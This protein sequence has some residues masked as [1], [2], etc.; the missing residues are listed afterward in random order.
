MTATQLKNVIKNLKYIPVV[1]G[2]ITI[3]EA[4]ADVLEH[5]S[6]IKEWHASFPTP[7]LDDFEEAITVLLKLDTEVNSSRLYLK[8]T[9]T[10]YGET[11][12]LFADNNILYWSRQIDNGQFAYTE[13]AFEAE[14]KARGLSSKKCKFVQLWPEPWEHDKVAEYTTNPLVEGEWAFKPLPN[15]KSKWVRV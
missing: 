13:Q 15:N 2:K 11:Y 1:Y 10:A 14:R 5:K 4:S 6:K 9:E 7:Q 8:I 3:Q 12:C